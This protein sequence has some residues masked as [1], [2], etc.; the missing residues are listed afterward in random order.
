[1][2][3]SNTYTRIVLSVHITDYGYQAVNVQGIVININPFIVAILYISEI[4]VIC[5]CVCVCVQSVIEKT[6]QG[7]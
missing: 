5:V 3:S 7:I 6:H 4:C 1:V 2:T